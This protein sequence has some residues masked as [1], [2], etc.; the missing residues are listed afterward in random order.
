MACNGCNRNLRGLGEV[1]VGA[2]SG[3]VN[4]TNSTVTAL[5]NNANAATINRPVV[6]GVGARASVVEGRDHFLAS[7]ALPRQGNLPFATPGGAAQIDMTSTGVPDKAGARAVTTTGRALPW[8]FEAGPP[9]KFAV[10]SWVS[11]WI[12]FFRI[13]KDR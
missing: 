9:K 11:P 7:R 8:T 1:A 5:K 4:Q 13:G 12:S 10:S 3:G 6:V 2:T